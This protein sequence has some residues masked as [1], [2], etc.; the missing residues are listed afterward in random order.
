[1]ARKPIVIERSSVVAAPQA[2]VWA[3][4]TTFVGV[5]RE[6]MPLCKMRVPRALRGRTLDT[7][8]PGERAGCWLL[9][10]GVVPFDR[11]RLGLESI[12]PGVGFV[13]ESTSW[14][15]RRWRHERTLAPA[16]IGTRVTDRVTVEPRLFLARP[17]TR[18]VVGRVFRHRHVRL[19]SRFGPG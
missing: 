2:E 1:M 5:N 15:H 8:Q 4:A 14:L 10:F 19:L 11:H 9:A 3:A 16:G 12:E 7:Y 13:E 18:F 6:L 17:L